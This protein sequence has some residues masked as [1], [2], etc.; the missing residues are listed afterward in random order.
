MK[1]RRDQ[2]EEL[3]ERAGKFSWSQETRRYFGIA[4][5]AIIYAIGFNYFLA[6]LHLYAGGFMGFSQLAAEQLKRLGLQ[7]GSFEL[8]GALYYLFNIPG[9]I[10]AYRMMRRRFII[11]TFFAITLVSLLL[12]V[13]PVADEPILHEYVAN[14]FFAGLTCGAGLGIILRMGACDGGMNLVGMIVV[15]KGTASSIGRL[16]LMVNALLFTCCL[17]LYDVSIV[18]YSLLFSM[19]QSTVIDK[20]HAQNINVRVMIVTKSAD[21]DALEVEIMGQL[22]RGVTKWNAVGAYSGEKETLLMI[23][24]SKYEIPKIRSLTLESD[25][26]AFVLVD[27]NVSVIGNFM[28]NLT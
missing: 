25:P 24:A 12:T 11:K 14:A 22:G 10:I 17:F 13:I 23:V 1:S 19:I 5:G 27:E 6:P 4:L 2:V 28:K 8:Q 18:V 20:V 3:K 21:P 16:S 7:P 26:N 9:I 15:Q